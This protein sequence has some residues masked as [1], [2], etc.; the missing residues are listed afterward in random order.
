[1]KQVQEAFMAVE[2]ELTKSSCILKQEVRVSAGEGEPG[3]EKITAATG[4][5]LPHSHVPALILLHG[6][7]EV[8]RAKDSP[9]H[10]S[11]PALNSPPARACHFPD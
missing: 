11:G 7:G 10:P 3:E 6:C 2:I 9:A 1:M 5:S 8:P 4:I